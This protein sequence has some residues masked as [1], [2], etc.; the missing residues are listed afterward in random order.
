MYFLLST[1]CQHL[2]LR[3]R[4][5]LR[6][7]R[8]CLHKNQTDNPVFCL[9]A[10]PTKAFIRQ[11]H[12]RGTLTSE[13]SRG[14]GALTCSHSVFL[15]EAI[16]GLSQSVFAQVLLK[17]NNLRSLLSRSQRQAHSS[18]SGL[19]SRFKIFMDFR[20]VLQSCGR[21]Y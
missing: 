4:I 13:W 15:W 12:T 3:P 19:F 5:Y 20:V 11:T 9:N 14:Q 10:A 6:S 16:E 17:A 7:L 8:V 18:D 21:Q 1:T 2:N